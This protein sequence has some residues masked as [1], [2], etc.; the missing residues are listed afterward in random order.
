MDLSTHDIA[1]KD[2]KKAWGDMIKRMI[3]EENLDAW[4]VKLADITHNLSE[5]HNC[6]MEQRY[7]YLFAKAP[8]FI[9]Y[10]NKYFPE[11]GLYKEFIENYWQQVRAY[12]NY[13]S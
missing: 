6:T 4:A 13:F 11:S 9:Y 10:G 8:V 5:C 1:Q 2:P 7:G 3:I 12:H